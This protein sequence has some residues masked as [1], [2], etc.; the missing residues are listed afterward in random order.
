MLI[1]ICDDSKAD[2]LRL[3]RNI[4][5]YA[6]ELQASVTIQIFDSADAMLDNYRKRQDKPAIIFLDIYMDG[7]NGMDA[8]NELVGLGMENGLVFT[9]SSE[10]HAL[11]AFSIGADGYLHKPFTHEEFNRA[12][13]RFRQLFTD[14]RRF[15][16]AQFNREE[17]HVYLN[18]IY[19]AESA[20]HSTEFNTS[21]GLIRSSAPL[22]SYL[23]ELEGEEGFLVCG[24]SYIVNINAVRDYD[25]ES[26]IMKFPDNSTICV[27]VRLRREVRQHMKSVVTEG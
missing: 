25:A 21:A 20:G 12:M 24:R 1:F 27:P 8:A 18:S 13:K 4:N 19:F 17:T 3:V 15:V 7:T 9:T 11:Q 6:K 26:G 14:S 22:S 16:T 5:N 10:V 2:Q 23:P